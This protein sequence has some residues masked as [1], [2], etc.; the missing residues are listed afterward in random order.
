MPVTGHSP[1][2]DDSKSLVSSRELINWLFKQHY[3]PG[4][5]AIQPGRSVP[6]FQRNLLPP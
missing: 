2:P 6:M 3:P 4:C 5:D 1:G